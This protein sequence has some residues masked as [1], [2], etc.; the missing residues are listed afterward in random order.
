[1]SLEIY[2]DPEKIYDNILSITGKYLDNNPTI[3]NLVIGLSGGIDSAL[4][5]ALA[6]D[7]CMHYDSVDI[8]GVNIPLLDNDPEGN[9]RAEIVADAFCNT[10]IRSG[11]SLAAKDFISNGFAEL[12]Y[13]DRNDATFEE[14]VRLGNIM[15]R[16]RMI[17]LYD[18]AQSVSDH[19]IH[20]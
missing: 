19:F 15:A 7:I 12:D 17:K 10:F 20:K 3:R 11:I 16:L 13:W 18:I 1:M 6:H 8:I 5:A 2:N 9:E 4:A 14:K